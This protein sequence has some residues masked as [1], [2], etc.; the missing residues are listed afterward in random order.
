MLGPDAACRRRQAAWRQAAEQTFWRPTGVKGRAQTGQVIVTATL[1]DG[2]MAIR[3][4]FHLDVPSQLA[5][6]NR[7]HPAEAW[8]VALAGEGELVCGPGQAIEDALGENRV[9]EEW[10]PVLRAAV[11][12]DNE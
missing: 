6:G 1:R 9:R 11:R 3:T 10:I 2:D 8:P 4:S 5:F 12:G 7:G